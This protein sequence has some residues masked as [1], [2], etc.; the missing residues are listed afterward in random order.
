M[1]R[2]PG[3]G[4]VRLAPSTPKLKF[5]YEKPRH[6]LHHLRLRR[7]VLHHLR[8]RLGLRRAHHPFAIVFV[9]I[10]GRCDGLPIGDG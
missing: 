2:R 4:Q 10:A 9:N 8:L 7:L 5:P 1:K 3:P 6:L